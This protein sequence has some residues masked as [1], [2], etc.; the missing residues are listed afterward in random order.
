MIQGSGQVTAR[1]DFISLSWNATLR[2]RH[3]IKIL[4]QLPTPFL[5]MKVHA[6]LIR[7]KCR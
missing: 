5:R 3:L 2:K 1:Y 7:F 4:G 6:K